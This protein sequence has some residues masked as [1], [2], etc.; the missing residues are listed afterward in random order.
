MRGCDEARFGGDV[1]IDSYTYGKWRGE[2]RGKE[3]QG[4]FGFWG[5]KG[6]VG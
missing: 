4:G 3:F 2:E 6:V 5:R 1:R